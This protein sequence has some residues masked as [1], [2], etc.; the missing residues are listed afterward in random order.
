M[1]EIFKN[2][3]AIGTAQK[4][5]WLQLKAISK[6]LPLISVTLTN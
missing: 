5:K 4:E 1:T 2:L 6:V 3:R